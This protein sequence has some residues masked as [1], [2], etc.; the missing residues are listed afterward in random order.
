MT[1][2]SVAEDVMVS[3]PVLA[4]VVEALGH[5]ERFLRSS[6]TARA[7]LVEYCYP[8]SGV[9]SGGLVEQLAWHCLYF[10]TRLAET[11][12]PGDWAGASP[13]LNRP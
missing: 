5:V 7:E 10:R 3:G 1:E 13:W 11:A 12:K 2:G 8:R 6:D 9:T 4:Q